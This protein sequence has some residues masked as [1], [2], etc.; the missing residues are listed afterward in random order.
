[1]EKISQ[2][3]RGVGS[4]DAHPTMT[5]FRDSIGESERSGINWKRK[6][7]RSMQNSEE[8]WGYR[9]AYRFLDDSGLMKSSIEEKVMFEKRNVRWS[10]YLICLD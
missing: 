4:K 10:F 7:R 6:L 3:T 8:R 2:A 5:Y 9:N 1:M